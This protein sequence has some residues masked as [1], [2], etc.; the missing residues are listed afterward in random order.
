MAEYWSESD[1]EDMEMTSVSKQDSP[2]PPYDTYPRASS[3]SPTACCLQIGIEAHNNLYPCV[4]RWVPTWSPS[5]VT[6]P[7][8]THSSPAPLM[9]S[10][11]QSPSMAAAAATMA[12][13]PGRRWVAT[14]TRGRTRWRPICGCSTCRRFPGRRPW[15]LT[16]VINWPWSTEGSPPCRRHEACC[17]TT[18]GPCPCPSGQASIRRREENP[19]ASHYPGTV[20]SMPS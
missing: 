3:V 11:T 6:S 10:S 16:T 1:H 18:T 12:S 8:P 17:R 13:R 14:E 19:A 15:W 7:P 5:A 4:F 20:G 9:R 2:P